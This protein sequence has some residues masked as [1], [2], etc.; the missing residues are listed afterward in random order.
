MSIAIQVSNVTFFAFVVTSFVAFV[1]KE[2]IESLVV[3][4][5]APGIGRR[6]D[7]RN[8]ARVDS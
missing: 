7:I 3:H 4:P 2:L 8:K 6:Q 1:A 5:F